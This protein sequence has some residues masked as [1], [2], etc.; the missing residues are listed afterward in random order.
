MLNTYASDKRLVRR[1]RRGDKGAYGELVERYKNLVFATLL[2]RVRHSEDVEDLAQ[3]VFI[4][5]YQRLDSLQKTEKFA[6][7]LRRIT[8]HCADDFLRSQSAL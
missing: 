4:K 1:A 3:D 7:W 8:A 2:T 5:V 6:P